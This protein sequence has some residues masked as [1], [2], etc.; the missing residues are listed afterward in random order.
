MGPR[1]VTP[2]PISATPQDP[3]MPPTASTTYE[4]LRE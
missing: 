3:P 2:L 4:R 1:V